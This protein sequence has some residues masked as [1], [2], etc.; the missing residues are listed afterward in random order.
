LLDWF[1]DPALSVTEHFTF[2]AP[3][4]STYTC[5]PYLGI[6]DSCPERIPLAPPEEGRDAPSLPDGVRIPGADAE[7]SYPGCGC[8]QAGSRN[9]LVSAVLFA[10]AIAAA[11]RRS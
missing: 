3:F 1:F 8:A 7:P 9:S 10:L 11:R 2:A 5:H 6:F 4:S